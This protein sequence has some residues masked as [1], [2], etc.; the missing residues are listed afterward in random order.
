VRGRVWDSLLAN[1]RRQERRRI[2]PVFQDP[3]G[4]FDP[5][6]T[7]EKV[8]DEALSV[9]GY[10]SG[11]RRRSRAAALLE[12]VRLDQTFLGRRP[13]ELSGGQRQRV[14]IARA[15]APEPEVILCDE[16]ISSL[17]VSVQ[18]QILDLLSDLQTRFRVACIFI[19]H[20]LGVIRRMSNQ[21]LIMKDGLVVE[22]GDAATVFERPQ[23]EYTRRLLDA[24]PPGPQIKTDQPRMDAN[25]REGEPSSMARRGSKNSTT[26]ERRF[27]Q[28]RQG[29]D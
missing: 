16:P 25:R 12:L 20:D 28:M 5:R 18:A 11:L 14:A 3:L 6:F 1:E 13:I 21:V 29:I 27:T 15:L 8:L 23:H 19:S 26:D 2:Q 10:P 9:A 4:L 17:D 7:V 22:S 24:I